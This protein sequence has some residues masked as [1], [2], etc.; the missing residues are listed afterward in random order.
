MFLIYNTMRT[1]VWS[2]LATLPSSLHS[3]ASPFSVLRTT[4]I[5][6]AIQMESLENLKIIE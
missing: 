6:I 2:D 4:S 3:A 1:D 5:H